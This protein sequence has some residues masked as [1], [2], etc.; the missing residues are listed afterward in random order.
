[1][2]SKRQILAGIFYQLKN[3]CNWGDLP[4]TF[5]LILEFIGIINQWRKEGVIE[6]IRS[7]LHS[8]V[9]EQ[10]KKHLN[11]KNGAFRRS[12]KNASISFHFGRMSTSEAGCA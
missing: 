2:W 9:R 1:M 8:Q 5:L 6:E 12:A 3:G 4:K 7:K 11:A 10:V